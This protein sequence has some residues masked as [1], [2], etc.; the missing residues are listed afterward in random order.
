M[1]APS[2]LCIIQCSN[3]RPRIIKYD[4]VDLICMKLCLKLSIPKV[5]IQQQI[6]IIRN[7]I[8]NVALIRV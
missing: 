6:Q 1:P 3:Y 5:S 4:S 7:F 8:Q 2:A